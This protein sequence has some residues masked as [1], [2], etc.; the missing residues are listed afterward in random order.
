MSAQVGGVHTTGRCQGV[1]HLTPVAAVLAQSV[2]QHQRPGFGAAGHAVGDLEVPHT[3][4][5]R[6]HHRVTVRPTA[7]SQL[8]FGYRDGLLVPH[9]PRPEDGK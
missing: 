8:P 1:D 2:Q 5:R 7:S 6:I 4:N 3:H 9:S